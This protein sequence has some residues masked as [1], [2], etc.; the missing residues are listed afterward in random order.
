M[1]KAEQILSI[2]PHRYPMLL[3]D[4]VL[5]IDP[6]KRVVG[7]KNVSMNE[8]FFMGHWPGQPVMPGVLIVECMAQVSAI[9]MLSLPDHESQLAFIA[10]IDKMRFRKPVYPGDAMILEAVMQKKRGPMGVVHIKAHVEGELVAEGEI[11]FALK[12]R[13]TSAEEAK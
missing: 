3:V 11:M 13:D 12:D 4:R 5:E 1:L 9:M 10:G 2:L 6:G 8:P 7:L